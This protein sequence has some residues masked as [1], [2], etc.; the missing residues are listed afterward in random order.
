[1]YHC[2]FLLFTHSL[3][4]SSLYPFF[5]VDCRGKICVAVVRSEGGDT[6]T[7]RKKKKSHKKLFK[8]DKGQNKTN[9][10]TQK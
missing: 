6:I 7:C 4:P 2:S 9:R 3:L 1:M 5:L 8:Q 10:E